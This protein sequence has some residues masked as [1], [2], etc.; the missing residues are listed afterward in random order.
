VK[1]S[2]KKTGLLVAIIMA[3]YSVYA[4][5]FSVSATVVSSFAAIEATPLNLG[6]LTF[7][8]DP[9]DCLSNNKATFKSNGNS[10]TAVSNTEYPPCPDI[11]NISMSPPGKITITGGSPSTS[12]TVSL[13][14]TNTSNSEPPSAIA[15]TLDANGEGY[16]SLED[17]FK[18]EEI[19]SG[20]SEKPYGDSAY[21]VNYDITVDY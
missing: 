5:T 1:S 13:T 15:I 7:P 20:V 8:T 4:D 16:I 11:I 14:P 2:L 10:T 21:T 18:L 3:N 19:M 12:V 17:V 6:S 9:T